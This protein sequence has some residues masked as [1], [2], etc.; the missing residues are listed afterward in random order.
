M[1]HIFR[2]ITK[3]DFFFERFLLYFFKIEILFLLITSFYSYLIINMTHNIDSL[4]ARI[5]FLEKRIQSLLKYNSYTNTTPVKKK[6]ANA[7]VKKKFANAFK[8]HITS[9]FIFK[10]SY[11]PTTLDIKLETKALWNLLSKEEQS[12]WNS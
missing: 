8:S 9:Y 11:K 3:K 2:K 5:T 4:C 10:M 1:T 6:F 12:H 7:P